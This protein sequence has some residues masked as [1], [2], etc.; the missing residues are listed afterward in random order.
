MTQQKSVT[1]VISHTLDPEH[2]KRYEQWLGKIMP[3]AAEF[4]GHLGAN[5]IRPT[6]GQNLWSVIIRFDT[7]E[8][9]YAWTQSETRRELVAEIAPLLNEGDRTEVRTEPAFWFTPPAAN[10]RQPLRWKQF[11]MTL[12]VIFPSTNLVPWLTGMYLPSLRGSLL[13]HLI[14]DACVVALVVWFWMPIVTRLFAG[15]L[16]KN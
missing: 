6:A 7:I 1:L 9:L 5:V 13:L 11:L 2:G 14:N 15:W 3:V 16:K 8:H 10:V 4:P 12:L